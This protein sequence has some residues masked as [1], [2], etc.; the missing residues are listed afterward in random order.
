ML[1]KQK[2][3]CQDAREAKSAARKASDLLER[4][5]QLYSEDI[6][7]AVTNAKVRICLINIFTQQ[8]E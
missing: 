3:A 8:H 5:R 2:A 4:Q 7:I 1:L 6:R